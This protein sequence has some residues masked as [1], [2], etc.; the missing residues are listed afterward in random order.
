MKMKSQNSD[1][2][3]HFNDILLKNEISESHLLHP[4]DNIL[5]ENEISKSMIDFIIKLGP[6]IMLYKYN[7]ITTY[8]CRTN[9]MSI[10]HFTRSVVLLFTSAVRY[11]LL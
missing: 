4:N 11:T 10:T 9:I 7:I 3:H 6:D 2:L 8:R 1:L 5:C